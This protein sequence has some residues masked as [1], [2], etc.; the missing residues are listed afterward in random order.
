MKRYL[1]VHFKEKTTPDGEQVYFAVSKDGF[2]WEEI[3]NAN[4]VLWAYYGDKGVRDFTVVNNKG[5][6]LIIATD[7][8]L[9]YGMRSKY[10]HSWDKISRHGSKCFSVWESRDLV[11]WSEQRLIKIGNED[12][13]C[14]WAPDVIYDRKNE[15][16]ILHWSSSHIFNDF[17]DKGIY[18]ARTKDFE[19]FSE[20][21]VLHR[22]EGRDIIDSAMYEEDGMYYLFVKDGHPSTIVMLRSDSPTG[23]WERVEKFDECMKKIETGVY[24]A[25]TAVKLENGEWCLFLDYYG[26][27]GKEQGYIPF[28]STDISSG[29]FIRSDEKFNFPYKFKHGT[30]IEISEEEYERIKRHDWENVPDGR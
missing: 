1:F 6:Y 30:I 16:Y 24:E 18:Y 12:F 3:N 14:L 15:D 5:K 17:G 22:L 11:N 20:P 9:A 29:V 7:L 26:K 10:N 2:D 19:S 28:V 4:P 13:G 23:P 27:A 8:S 25:P 21:D